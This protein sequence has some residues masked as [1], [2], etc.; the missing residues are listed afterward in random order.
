MPSG[1]GRRA[2]TAAIVSAFTGVAG[3]L[4]GFF[5]VSTFVTSPTARTVTATVTATAT[6]TVTATVTAT[7][8]PGTGSGQGE[9]GT[10]TGRTPSPVASGT[11]DIPLTDIAPLHESG[12]GWQTTSAVTGGTRFDSAM[13]SEI[14]SYDRVIYS[15]NERYKSL[16][17]TVGLD[18]DSP[19]YPI[20]VKFSGGADREKPLK[21]VT[22]RINRPVQVSVDLTGIAIFHIEAEQPE[23]HT[24]TVVLGNPVLHRP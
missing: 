21:T 3:L 22:A 6:A 17:L 14:G 10:G 13:V 24:A 20:T 16:T 7:P 12:E 8:A 1:G 9:P 19:A 15:I 2:E 4:L 11:K 23:S 5:G 18:D